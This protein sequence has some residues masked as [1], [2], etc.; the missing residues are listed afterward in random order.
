MAKFIKL[1]EH[2]SDNESCEILVNVDNIE[3]VTK[4]LG[5]KTFGYQCWVNHIRIVETFDEVCT[6]ILNCK[7]GYIN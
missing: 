3:K 5:L 1:H 2:I 7:E 6:K 4:K